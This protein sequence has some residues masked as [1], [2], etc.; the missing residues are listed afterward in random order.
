MD[1]RVKGR[2]ALG[3]PWAR[4][5]QALSTLLLTREPSWDYVNTSMATILVSKNETSGFLLHLEAHCRMSTSLQQIKILFPSYS[6]YKD[7]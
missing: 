5:K 4:Q 2:S 6:S 7:E 1:G 3:K